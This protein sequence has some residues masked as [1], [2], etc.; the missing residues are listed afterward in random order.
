MNSPY[1]RRSLEEA[2]RAGRAPARQP[3]D[4]TLGDYVAADEKIERSIHDEE[5]EQFREAVARTWGIDFSAFGA[6]T[7]DL[8]L[9]RE[10][11]CCDVTPKEDRLRNDPTYTDGTFTSEADWEALA[12][13]QEDISE[14]AE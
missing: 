14:G 8:R 13:T 6:L 12:A 7:A 3:V 9:R 11:Y 2:A 1:V 10:D 5:C 4:F